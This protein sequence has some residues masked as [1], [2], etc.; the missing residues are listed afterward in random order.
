MAKHPTVKLKSSFYEILGAKPE[1]F[2]EEER[3]V[4][5]AKWVEI[6]SKVDQPM[7]DYWLNVSACEGCIYLKD[8]WCDHQGLPANYNPLLSPMGLGVGMACMGAAHTPREPEL[9]SVW[10]EDF[11]IDSDNSETLP[12]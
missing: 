5:W 7:V 3:K 9:F 1:D 6:C 12:F 10:N 8:H 11:K 4:R 2:T